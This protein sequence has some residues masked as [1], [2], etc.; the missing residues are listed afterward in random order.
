MMQ[1]VFARK[2]GMSRVVIRGSVVCASAG[3]PPPPSEETGEA[4]WSSAV[5]RVSELYTCRQ[6]KEEAD[7]LQRGGLRAR[8]AIVTNAAIGHAQAAPRHD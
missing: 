3:S 7:R 4:Q 1:A 5:T 2:A 6:L 8:P